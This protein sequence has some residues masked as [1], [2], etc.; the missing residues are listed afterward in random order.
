MSEALLFKLGRL[1]GERVALERI[2]QKLEARH[3]CQVYQQAWKI[4]AKEARAMKPDSI[5]HETCMA[6]QGEDRVSDKAAGP[7]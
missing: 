4:A 5:M 3:G 6:E 1:E 7:R 2:A